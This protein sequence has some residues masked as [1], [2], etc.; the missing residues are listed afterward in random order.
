MGSQLDGRWKRWAALARIWQRMR[1]WERGRAS[2]WT[3]RI[4]KER[5]DRDD[6]EDDLDTEWWWP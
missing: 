2:A 4:P 3:R 5:G 6:T 1:L